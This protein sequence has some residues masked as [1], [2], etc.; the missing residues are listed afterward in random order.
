MVDI[1]DDVN[2]IQDCNYEL[3]R[4]VDGSGTALSTP[5]SSSDFMTGE[6]DDSSDSRSII[7]FSL[8][9]VETILS[10]SK[11]QNKFLSIFYIIAYSIHIIYRIPG[12][13]R[14]GS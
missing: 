8:R 3:R 14:R 1:K 2:K 10:L 11:V 4:E 13:I 5:S 6:A 12:G 7:P 9:S